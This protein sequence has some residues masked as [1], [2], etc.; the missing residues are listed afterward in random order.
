MTSTGNS[1]R[2]CTCFGHSSHCGQ[3]IHSPLRNNS[4][5]LCPHVLTLR[6]YTIMTIELH[7]H[8]SEFPVLKVSSKCEGLS[9]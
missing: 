8:D 3:D 4:N 6:V 5:N 7:R 2:S 1:Y 9:L